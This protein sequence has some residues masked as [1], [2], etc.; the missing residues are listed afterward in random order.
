MATLPLD[1]EMNLLIK[2]RLIAKGS[3]SVVHGDDFFVRLYDKDLFNDDYLGQ[4]NLNEEGIAGFT[5]SQKD[6]S[7][8]FNIDTRPDFYFVVY[9]NGEEIFRSKVMSNLDLSNIQEFVM[10]EGEVIDLGT[11][12]IDTE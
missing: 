10:T 1:D 8:P 6:F 11:F 4:S 2:V 9:K 7:N 12:L 3:D 5:I